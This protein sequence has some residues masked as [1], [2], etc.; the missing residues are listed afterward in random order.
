MGAGTPLLTVRKASPQR[1]G[2]ACVATAGHLASLEAPILDVPPR[3]RQVWRI[4]QGG[5][6]I[7]VLS[8]L[9]EYVGMMFVGGVRAY[10]SWHHHGYVN[11]TGKVWCV[12][13][14]I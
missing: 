3:G 9:L 5:V 8:D 4:G 13:H 2:C 12:N 11:S 7:V 1:T 6:M 14:C 10:T